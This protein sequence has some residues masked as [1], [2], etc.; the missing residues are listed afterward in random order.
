MIKFKRQVGIEFNSATKSKETRNKIWDERTLW[1]EIIY[2]S[3]IPTFGSLHTVGLP[4][5]GIKLLLISH[6][7][8]LNFSSSQNL[9]PCFLTFVALL[10]SI[11]PYVLFKF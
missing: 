9:I 1:H 11:P 3:L 4:K 10:N 7:R 6:A 5:V 2:K 8:M